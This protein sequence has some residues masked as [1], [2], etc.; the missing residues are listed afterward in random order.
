MLFE[1]SHYLSPSPL[2]LWRGTPRPETLTYCLQ[3]RTERSLICSKSSSLDLN[4]NVVIIYGWIMLLTCCDTSWVTV[5]DILIMGLNVGS[6]RLLCTLGSPN[7]C[8]LY[9]VIILMSNFIKMRGCS[10]RKLLAILLIFTLTMS[11]CLPSHN[12][13]FETSFTK[14]RSLLNIAQT[15]FGIKHSPVCTWY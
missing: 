7:R 10:A 8:H 6:S 5:P 2:H 3:G 4:T 11:Q 14:S 12:L 9:I 15:V 1:Y 13:N